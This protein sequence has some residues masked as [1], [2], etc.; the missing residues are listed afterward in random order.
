MW[1][2][3]AIYRHRRGRSPLG[4]HLRIVRANRATSQEPS[5]Q[6]VPSILGLSEGKA[7]EH[8]IQTASPK[9]WQNLVLGD[10]IVIAN[11]KALCRCP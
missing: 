2:V 11:R 1:A 7:G 10:R 6:R 8:L 5:E 9:L 3:M 4:R